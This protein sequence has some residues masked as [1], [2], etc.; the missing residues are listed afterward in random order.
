[1]ERTVLL[2]ALV[3]LVALGIAGCSSASP[4]G[5]AQP[6]GVGDASVTESTPPAIREAFEAIERDA[7]DLT[8]CD[9]FGAAFIAWIC[10]GNPD[11]DPT[12]SVGLLPLS[13]WGGVGCSTDHGQ[14]EAPARV[15]DSCEASG[16]DDDAIYCA[17]Y[18]VTDVDFVCC[19]KDTPLYDS[20]VRSQVPCD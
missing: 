1:M 3:A 6:M 15:S 11:V 18:A 14:G 13:D 20:V 2:V 5:G 7:G 10:A 12:L 4:E 8:A 19:L 17:A 16:V 9:Y